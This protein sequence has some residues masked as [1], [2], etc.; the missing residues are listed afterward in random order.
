MINGIKTGKYFR[1][2]DGSARK[3]ILIVEDIYRILPKLIEKGGV[4]NLCDNHHP[5]FYELEEL[6]VKQLNLK[7]PKA[8]PF[9][10]A[11]SIAILGDV[12]GVKAP[13]N[14]SKLNKITQTLT[15][16]NEKAKREL[17]W[18]P[19]DVLENFKLK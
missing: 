19:L 6:I 9:W 4:Y 1:I 8:L 5:S 14:S 13:I 12:I 3:S 2:G 15:F 17:D 11:K 7:N 10:L 18:E 16:S